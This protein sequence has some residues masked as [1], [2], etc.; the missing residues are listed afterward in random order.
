[1]KILQDLLR[2]LLPIRYG[3]EPYIVDMK[4]GFPQTMLQAGNWSAAEPQF[5][6]I[7]IKM[8]PMEHVPYCTFYFLEN[9]VKNFKK[10]SFHR[11]A[12]HVLQAMIGGGNKAA[13]FAF[14][15]YSKEYPH[16]KY[17]LGYAGRPSSAHALYIST[18]DNSGNHGPGSQ[19][20]KTEADG[21]IGEILTQ[22][23][24]DVVTRMQQQPGAGKG[25][26][27]V[28]DSKNFIEILDLTLR[29]AKQ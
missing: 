12:S 16:K 19:G 11:R 17:T 28:S 5:A 15:E 22:Q 18:M 9:I 10:G 27:F 3:P 24:I 26:G 20:S 29:P 13:G 8:A 4:V 6:I 7:P 23:G 25:A 21:I 1:V 14:Q 2:A